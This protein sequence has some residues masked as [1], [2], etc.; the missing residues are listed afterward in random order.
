MKLKTS[1]RIDTFLLLLENGL[2]SEDN[3]RK[4]IDTSNVVAVGSLLDF[5]L[6]EYQGFLNLQESGASDYAIC[7]F[8]LS[9]VKKWSERKARRR[10]SKYRLSNYLGLL[11]H[12]FAEIE[13]VRVA[14]ENIPKV[15]KS[16]DVEAILKR[17]KDYGMI[18]IIDAMA[19]RY[20]ITLEVASKMKLLLAITI[21]NIQGRNDRAQHLMAK[22][23]TKK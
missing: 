1:D 22:K 8:Y 20:S 23:I 6:D 14:F 19:T 17:G 3:Y 16:P 10:V 11:K 18:E 15:P 5:T 13:R 12:L 21:M 9:I 4:A 7:T 2:V